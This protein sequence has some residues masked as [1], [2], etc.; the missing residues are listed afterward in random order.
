[1]SESGTRKLSGTALTVATFAVMAFAI[2]L[3]VTQY[4]S[5][6]SLWNDEE[7]LALNIGRRSPLGLLHVL[8]HDQAAPVLFLQ[9]EWL[10]TRLA[11]MSEPALR[12]LPFL[13]GLALVLL[14]FL[15]LRRLTNAVHAL[16]AIVVVAAS[17]WLMQFATEVKP[18]EGDAAI[19]ALLI[20]LALRVIDEPDTARWRHL[21]VAGVIAPWLSM[22]AIFVVASIA[23]ALAFSPAVRS[24]HL[25]RWRYSTMWPVWLASGAANFFLFLLPAT[26]NAYLQRQALWIEPEAGIAGINNLIDRWTNS[27]VVETFFRSEIVGKS[28]LAVGAVVATLGLVG[29]IDLARRRGRA[30][31][32][33]IV[34]PIVMSVAAL[35]AHVYPGQPRLQLWLVPS[36]VMLTVAGL[37]SMSRR[38]PVLLEAG[39]PLAL[40]A[41]IALVN[42]PGAFVRYYRIGYGD[43]TVVTAWKSQRVDSIPVYVAARAGPSWAFYTTDWRQPD[44]ARLDWYARNNASTGRAFRNAASRGRPVK[45]EGA[46][47]IWRSGSRVELLGTPSGMLN[48]AGSVEPDHPDTDW[49]KN[50]AA[51]IRAISSPE[52]WVYFAFYHNRERE[53]VLSAID[54]LGGQRVQEHVING[55]ALYRYRFSERSILEPTVASSRFGMRTPSSPGPSVPVP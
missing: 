38:L 7:L 15:L 49:E 22:P 27:L 52:V 2:A 23:I 40:A 10:A 21:I 53:L 1:M 6:P 44:T 42:W 43:R 24:N 9:L 28:W 46:D 50:E 8:D 32:L 31:A 18:Y 47:I 37:F 39:P 54:A 36:I 20:W 12:F 5:N 48:R 25:S 17:P 41:V 30:V 14:L 45:D 11:G 16:L 4:A 3:R 35:A 33:V 55:T 34:L 13:A 51:N 29:A 26:R 19:A